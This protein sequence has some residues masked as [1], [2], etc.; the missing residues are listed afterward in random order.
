MKS[1]DFELLDKYFRGELQEEQYAKGGTMGSDALEAEIKTWIFR[2]SGNIE[3]ALR[4][5]QYNSQVTSPFRLVYSAVRKGFIEPYQINADLLTSAI[6]T[7]DDIDDTYADSGEGFG[8]SDM[9]AYIGQMISGAGITI[10]PKMAEGGKVSN[11]VF[12]AQEN[13]IL[14]I[15]SGSDAYS[16][17]VEKG[18]KFVTVVNTLNSPFRP[19]D[20]KSWW[21]VKKVNKTPSKMTMGNDFDYDNRRSVVNVNWDDLLLIFPKGDK[22]IYAEMKEVSK[23][24]EGGNVSFSGTSPNL[25]GNGKLF[26]VNV[27][28][29]TVNGMEEDADLIQMEVDRY[30][31]LRKY[32]DFDEVSGTYSFDNIYPE[33]Q[34]INFYKDKM[35]VL[36]TIQSINWD[37][38]GDDEGFTNEIIEYNNSTANLSYL[39][40]NGY[41]GFDPKKQY[42]QEVKKALTELKNYPKM[43]VSNEYTKS[44]ALNE[45][46]DQIYLVTIIVTVGDNEGRE[47]IFWG[48]EVRTESGNYVRYIQNPD[49]FLNFRSTMDSK[50]IKVMRD[51]QQEADRTKNNEIIDGM[52][53]TEIPPI[54][55]SYS[56][57]QHYGGAE[58]G[59][60]YYHTREAIEEVTEPQ[61]L[62]IESE[63]LDSYG[64]GISAS[65]G[66]IFGEEEKLGR[67]YYS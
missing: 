37:D 5:V 50:D 14:G 33:T 52:V 24:A 44:G 42:E 54:Y 2:A 53:M 17:Q 15:F 30:N 65:E 61:Y 57:V 38:E 1:K 11:K 55:T 21:Y 8:S 41:T 22:S 48:L 9:N 58:E 18:D 6:E 19:E 23:M 62:E 59:G 46:P 13:G 12:E 35:L 16:I 3:D 4:F 40:G 10:K 27:N 60:W 66:F 31:I 43:G 64:E 45:V 67:E 32:F 26:K 63:R 28:W 25:Y 39:Y 47:H 29:E 7:S 56:N 20:D 36:S 49:D 34:T 51:Y